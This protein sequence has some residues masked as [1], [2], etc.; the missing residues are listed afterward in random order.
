LLLRILALVQQAVQE[1]FRLQVLPQLV[2]LLQELSGVQVFSPQLLALQE[3]AQQ[4][5]VLLE[6]QVLPL[7]QVPLPPPHW[8]GELHPLAPEL[9][10]AH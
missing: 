4:L 10:P 2:Q 5:Q 3:R 1:L 8:W 7:G 6:R 9:A